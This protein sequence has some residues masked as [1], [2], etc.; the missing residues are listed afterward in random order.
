MVIWALLLCSII[1]GA[2]GQIF[3][4]E[5]MKAAGPVPFE[6]SFAV[7]WRYFWNALLSWRMF[8]AAGSYG[9]S[10]LLWLAVLSRS[11]LSLARP[12]MSLGYLITLL[13]GVY[14]AESITA[15]RIWGTLLIVA[16]LVLVARS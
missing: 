15:M 13:Y 5:A 9:I 3:M 4:K 1:L 12:L 16:G 2:F 14:A 10:F 6:L 8:A 11:D 7:L